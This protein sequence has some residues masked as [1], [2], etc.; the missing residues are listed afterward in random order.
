LQFKLPENAVGYLPIIGDDH[1]RSLNLKVNYRSMHDHLL[2]VRFCS[3][4]EATITLGWCVDSWRTYFG[5]VDLEALDRLAIPV[6][7]W[8]PSL[9]SSSSVSSSLEEEASDKTVF[10]LVI[11]WL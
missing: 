8:W 5:A 10:P 2:D 6:N 7:F 3:D 9:A 4:G 11:N 1:D